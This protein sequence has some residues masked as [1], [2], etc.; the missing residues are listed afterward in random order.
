MP[1]NQAGKP[2]MNNFAYE[3]HFKYEIMFI[4]LVVNMS[5]LPEQNFSIST[6][7]EFNSVQLEGDRARSTH[8]LN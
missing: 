3:I 4:P 5:T 8:P 7:T 1:P 2:K 6:A